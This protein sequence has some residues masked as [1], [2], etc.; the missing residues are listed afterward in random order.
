MPK[1]FTVTPWE[2][3][4]DIDYDK[5][6]KEFGVSKIIDK[7]LELI[8]KYT[9]ELHHFLRR[10]IFFAHR[11]LKF[12]LDEYEKGNKF[13]LYTGRAPSG[14]VHIGHMVPW[15]FTKWL[16]DKFG[17]ELYFQ[18]P[19]EE[20]FLFKSDLNWKESQ[21]YLEDNMLD[22]IAMGFDQKK[23]HFVIDSKHA[24]IMYPEA[25]KVAKRIT[26]SMIKSAFG[27]NNE[28]NIGIIFYTAMQAVPAFLPCVMKN[29][30]IPCLIPHA[31]DQDVHFRLSR[32]VIPKLGYYKPASIQ[33]RFLP[34]LT[35]ISSDGKMS[36]SDEHTAVYTTDDPKTVKKKIMKYAFSGGQPTVEEHRKKGGNPEIDVSYQWLTFFEEDDKKLKKIYND[37]RSGKMLTG[38]LKQILID[39]INLILSEHQKRRE[40]AKDVLDKFIMKV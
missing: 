18:F 32:D 4:G 3:K 26:F 39:K 24:G 20:K 19:D 35:G 14:K 40:K 15:M 33:C 31:I 34:G 36:S 27:F 29:K 28:S 5:L 6:I 1:K 11:D 16:Q 13:F 37:Y 9:D 22:V 25:L 8:K 17:V 2:V 23:T 38:E 7:H 30:K 12:I 10:G 21:E